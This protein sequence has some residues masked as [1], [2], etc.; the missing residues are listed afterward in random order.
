M[1]S[2]AAVCAISDPV[3]RIIVFSSNLRE[4]LNYLSGQHWKNWPKKKKAACRFPEEIPA[5]RFVPVMTYDNNSFTLC[6]TAA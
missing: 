1:P 6:C 4:L 2:S 5:G 3:D